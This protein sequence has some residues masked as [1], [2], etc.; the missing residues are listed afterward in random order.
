[1]K[2]VPDIAVGGDGSGLAQ[3]LVAKMLSGVVPKV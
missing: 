1:M 2:L 3:V